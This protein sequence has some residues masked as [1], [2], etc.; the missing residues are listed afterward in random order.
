MR[1]RPVLI[2]MFVSALVSLPQPG[3]GADPCA[4]PKKSGY[5]FMAK[6][7]TAYAVRTARGPNIQRA[8]ALESELSGLAGREDSFVSKAGALQGECKAITSLYQSLK[9][10]WQKLQAERKAFKAKKKGI[11]EEWKPVFRESKALK[12]ESNRLDSIGCPG[13]RKRVSKEEA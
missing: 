2:A 9:P 7:N 10:K 5:L 3:E 12:A 13:G 1:G 11:N 6:K 4:L 8:K